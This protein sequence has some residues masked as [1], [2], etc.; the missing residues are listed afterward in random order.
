MAS[1]HFLDLYLG[2]YH[3]FFFFV[4]LIDVEYVSNL[5]YLFL[6]FDLLNVK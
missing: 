2:V 3:I 6:K 4:A 5:R 1:E